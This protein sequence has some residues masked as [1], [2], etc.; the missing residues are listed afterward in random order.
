M[1]SECL[2]PGDVLV[3]PPGGLTM[4]CDAVLLSGTAIVN[5]SMLTGEMCGVGVTSKMGGWG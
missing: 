5:E 2:V 3:V 1:H 4:P